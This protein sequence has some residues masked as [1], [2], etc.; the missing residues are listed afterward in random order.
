MVKDAAIST[1][2]HS[3]CYPDGGKWSD[4]RIKVGLLKFI[5]VNKINQ[6]G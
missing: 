5:G 3:E 2:E 1:G 6:K 4:I